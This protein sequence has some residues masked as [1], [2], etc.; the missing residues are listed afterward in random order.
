MIFINSIFVSSAIFYVD[1]TEQRMFF[2][3]CFELLQGD[4]HVCHL[5]MFNIR[6]TV[7][8]FIYLCA[9]SCAPILEENPIA[10]ASTIETA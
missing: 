9:I 7:Q 2:V 1:F 3:F 6:V 4:A 8:L 5:T 10:G